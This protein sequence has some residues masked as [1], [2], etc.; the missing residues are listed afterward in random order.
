MKNIFYHMHTFVKKTIHTREIQTTL[1]I[2]KIVY[3]L[4]YLGELYLVLQWK[5]FLHRPEEIY[6]EV[7]Y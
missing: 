1:F 7:R 2:E 6:Y 4:E 5:K 3:S